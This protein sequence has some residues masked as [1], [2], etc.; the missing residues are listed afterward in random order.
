MTERS[1][2]EYRV[3]L[4]GAEQYRTK[5]KEAVIRHYQ[6]LRQKH[7][8]RLYTIQSRTVRWTSQGEIAEPWYII[9]ETR[10]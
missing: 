6:S 5:S 10:I 7:P 1:R 8:M 9:G 4:H 3:C 2:Q